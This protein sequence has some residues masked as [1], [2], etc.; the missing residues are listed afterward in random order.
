MFLKLSRYCAVTAR[1]TSWNRKLLDVLLISE[2]PT[3]ISYLKLVLL[4]AEIGSLLLPEVVRLDDVRG[5][6]GVTEVVLQ[7]LQNGLDSAPTRVPPH[8]YHHAV[9]EISN[10]LAEILWNIKSCLWLNS[11]I[12]LFSCWEVFNPCQPLSFPRSFN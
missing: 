3:R 8:V 4:A 5:V 1:D 12:A 6:H 2:F 11:Y 10:I 9:P 7:N